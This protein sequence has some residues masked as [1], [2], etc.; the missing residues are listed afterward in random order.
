MPDSESDSACAEVRQLSNARLYCQSFT[1]PLFVKREK[2][3]KK[4]GLGS[5]WQVE[6]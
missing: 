4:G 2:L 3:T 1:V 5:F 6:Y